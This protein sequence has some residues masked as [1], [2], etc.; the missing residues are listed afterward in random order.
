MQILMI[1]ILIKIDTVDVNVTNDS[2][3]V[4]TITLTETEAYSGIFSG[5]LPT[6]VQMTL[7]YLRMVI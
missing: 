3:D 1:M 7:M 6:V 4:E 2:G 5:S